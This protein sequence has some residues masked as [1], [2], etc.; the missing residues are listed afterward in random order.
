MQKKPHS[1]ECWCTCVECMNG[2]HKVPSDA[3]GAKDHK[4]WC[5]YNA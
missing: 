3:Q 5:R 1:G 4:E 2:T